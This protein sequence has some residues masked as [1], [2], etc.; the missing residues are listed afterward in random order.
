MK[1][2]KEEI[3][4]LDLEETTFAEEVEE[5]KNKEE[6]EESGE[7]KEEPQEEVKE[8]V[9]E[10]PTEEELEK[11]QKQDA[12]RERQR[13]KQEEKKPVAQEEYDKIA[14]QS[15]KEPVET[16]KLATLEAKVEQYD[17]VVQQQNFDNAVKQADKELTALEVPFKEAF[18][19]YDDV[20]ADALELTKMRL[21]GQGVTDGEADD[22]LRREKV[23]IADRAAAAGKD[24]VEAVYKEAKDILGVFDAYAEK[25]GY[26]RGKP[27]TNM[28]AM[29]EISKPNAMAGG[30]GSAAVK[31]GYVDLDSE[32]VGELTMEQMLTGGFK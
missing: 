12:Y 26:T 30:S 23:M 15:V 5:L 13:A 4:K 32:E 31:K 21:T 2:L 7:I 19:D 28:Q 10:E 6:A 27:K 3:E 20:V 14:A 22:Y 11:K 16:D 8:E 17:K 29:R 24:P 25:K 1:A 18:T 9:K